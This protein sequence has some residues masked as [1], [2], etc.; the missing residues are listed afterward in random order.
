MP[1]RMVKIIPLAHA[2]I[3]L[4]SHWFWGCVSGISAVSGGADVSER[5]VDEASS[6]ELGKVS[7]PGDLLSRRLD[8]F[9]KIKKPVVHS[10]PA[11]P[12]APESDAQ[13]GSLTADADF[14]IAV[15]SGQWHDVLA[16]SFE[17]WRECKKQASSLSPE[18]V[19][20]GRARAWAF[21][22]IGSIESAWEIYDDMVDLGMKNS[23]AFFARLLEQ[24]GA[25]FLCSNMAQLYLTQSESDDRLEMAALNV[26]CLRRAGR[27][28]DS[29]KAVQSGLL[30]FPN[31][32][33]LLLELALTQLSE[34]KLTQGCDLLEQLYDNKVFD[35]AV[36]YNWGE[37]LVQRSDVDN[38]RIVLSRGRS[39]WPSE[40]VWHILAG[41]IARL[42][43]RAELARRLGREYLAGSNSEDELRGKAENLAEM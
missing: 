1:E 16:N 26:R 18:C 7:L 13:E 2:L 24:S 21:V 8:Q 29:K 27:I 14:K 34:N 25:Y 31:S 28:D 33:Q 10:S 15:N 37:C 41:E 11:L 4:F 39:E 23:S 3:M 38:A 19:L 35:V 6:S 42:E 5:T 9:A 20:I 30:E 36:I 43:G 22:K 17:P 40:R 32:G 12:K